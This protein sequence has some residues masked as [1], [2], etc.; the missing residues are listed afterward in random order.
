MNSAS[1]DHISRR[2]GSASAHAALTG[3][4]AGSGRS[5]ADNLGMSISARQLNRAT[6]GRQLLLPPNDLEMELNAPPRP[7]DPRPPAGRCGPLSCPECPKPV[8]K[9]PSRVQTPRQVDYTPTGTKHLKSVVLP[10]ARVGSRALR[11]HGSAD[12]APYNESRPC[13]TLIDEPMKIGLRSVNA[14][15]LDPTSFTL[16]PNRSAHEDATRAAHSGSSP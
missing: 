5:R 4:A 10:A 6:L 8:G 11:L 1:H 13:T 9:P 16:C 12:H 14:L 2:R 15:I 3:L 7:A